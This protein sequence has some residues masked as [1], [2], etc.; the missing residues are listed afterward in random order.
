MKN[1]TVEITKTKQT[2]N[3][4]RTKTT[5]KTKN[6]ETIV[7]VTETTMNHRHSIGQGN[8]PMGCFKKFLWIAALIF[9]GLCV[10]YALALKYIK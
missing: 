10:L 6:G 1:H 7:T 4:T 3:G 2:A 8:D 5:K 9:I